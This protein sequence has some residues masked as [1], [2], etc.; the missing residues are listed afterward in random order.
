MVEKLLQDDIINY[1]F[2]PTFINKFSEPELYGMIKDF[3]FPVEVRKTF[4]T[5]YI[6]LFINMNLSNNYIIAVDN[7]DVKSF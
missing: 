3:S 1:I 6:R 7:N 5:I 2:L 4:L